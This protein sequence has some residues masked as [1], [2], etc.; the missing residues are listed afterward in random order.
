V[1]HPP[2]DAAP[3]R[4]ARTTAPAIVTDLVPPGGYWSGVVRCGRI[5]RLTD[6]E[7]TGGVSL[8]A[9]NAHETSERY[10]APDTVKIQNQIY[11]TAGMVL[12][13]DLGRI[14]LSITADSSGCHDT[15]GGASDATTVAAAERHGTYLE[16]GNDRFVNAHDNLVAAV[17][18]HGLDRRDLVPTF[19]PFDRVTVEPDGR[20]RWVGPCGAAGAGLDLRAEMDVLVV[21]SNTPHALDPAETWATGPLQVEVLQDVEPQVD[22]RV[23]PS[24]ER[25]RGFDNTDR[26]VAL[27][28]GG[29][30]R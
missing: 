3:D 4:P 25:A 6:V 17:G 7:G 28:D 26:L 11:L 24:P 14:L 30:G 8:L 1:P 22:P 16:R 18:R 19:N 12:F 21:L 15:L 13:S 27:L 9:Y 23:D 10:N 20:L 2:A 29:N 5:L